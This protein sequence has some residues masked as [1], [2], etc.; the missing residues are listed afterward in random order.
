[1]GSELVFFQEAIAK[2]EARRT[3]APKLVTMMHENVALNAA[4]GNAIARNA[5]AATAVHV[6]VGTLHYGAA[7]HTAWRGTYPVLLIAGT[8]PPPLAGSLRRRATRGPRLD[9]RESRKR[10]GAVGPGA[11]RPGRDRAAVHQGR[12]PI[13]AP[14]QSR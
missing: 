5:P 3:P 13:G 8:R 2:A 12:P 10:G 6:D 7:T 11:A 14:G 4:L 1:S 9:A